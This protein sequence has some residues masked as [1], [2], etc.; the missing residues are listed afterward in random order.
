MN[1]YW[2]W[3]L[4]TVGGTGM[5]LAGRRIWWAWFVAML[6]EILWFTY[7]Y[8]TKQYGFIAGSIIYFTIFATNAY[9]WTKAH[10]NKIV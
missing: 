3:I 5:F 2:S 4:V 8:I 9:K 6:S 7:G 1:E 10:K